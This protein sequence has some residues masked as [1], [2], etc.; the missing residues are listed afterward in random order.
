MK[1]SKVFLSTLLPLCMA[2][3]VWA[4][5]VAEE[6]PVAEEAPSYPAHTFQGWIDQSIGFSADAEDAAFAM[7]E[8]AI[9]INHEINENFGGKLQ[10]NGRW[11]QLGVA[12]PTVVDGTGAPIG[13]VADPSIGNGSLSLLAREAYGYAQNDDGSMKLSVGKWYVPIGFE[14]ADPVDLYQYS[15]SNVF[16]HFLPTEA[17]GLLSYF[18]L[19]D[20][21]NLQLYL[22]AGPTDDD[23]VWSGGLGTPVIGERLGLSFGDLGLGVSL[24]I[25]PDAFDSGFDKLLVD[26]DAAYQL[27]KLLVGFEFAMHTAIDNGTV[28]T[29]IGVMAMLNYLVTDSIGLTGRVDMVAYDG[30]ETEI[31][32]TASALFNFAPGWDVV[33]ELREDINDGGTTNSDLTGA[34]ELI[35]QFIK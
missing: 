23:F 6:T 34:L 28:G 11:N 24:L 35:Y 14:L 1:M 22:A 10:L 15:N 7:F 9:R 21:I 12:D 2:G 32:L 3:S 25:G 17:L 27:E 16:G 5:E 13:T 18:G 4:E 29:D 19:S 26:V 33:V 30:A 31:G 8:A 20:N